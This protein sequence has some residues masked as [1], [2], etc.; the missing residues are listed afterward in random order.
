[1]KSIE[2]RDLRLIIIFLLF[3]ILGLG[4]TD[5]GNIKNRDFYYVYVNNTNSEVV[6]E[7]YDAGSKEHLEKISN[8]LVDKI[9]LSPAD[10]L[11]YQAPVRESPEVDKIEAPFGYVEVDSVVI[12][13]DD[14]FIKSFSCS[15]DSDQVDTTCLVQNSIMN[16]L[17]FDEQIVLSN[18]TIAI[19]RFSV[20]K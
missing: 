6:V 11:V 3:T 13:F 4:C 7:L 5:D 17:F 9:T 12:F 1:M 18:S 19:Y 20:L 10:S 14:M 2:L 8:A 16:S 15:I